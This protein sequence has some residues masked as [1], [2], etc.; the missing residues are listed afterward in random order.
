MSRGRDEDNESVFKAVRLGLEV[1]ADLRAYD[2]REHGSR[3][4]DSPRCFVQPEEAQPKATVASYTI[5]I[6]ETKLNQIKILEDKRR[7]A[8]DEKINEHRKELKAKIGEF[9]KDITKVQEYITQVQKDADK[10]EQAL[11]HLKNAFDKAKAT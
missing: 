3:E 11:K 8:S 4:H 9:R 6:I 7:Y 2:S 5:G 10:V 1:I